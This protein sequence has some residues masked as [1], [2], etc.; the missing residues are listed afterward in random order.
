MTRRAVELPPG[1][2]R[3]AEHGNKK[4]RQLALYTKGIND[5]NSNVNFVFTIFAT[6][7]TSA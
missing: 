7:V 2:L 3:D 5:F 1:C 4:C 6:S